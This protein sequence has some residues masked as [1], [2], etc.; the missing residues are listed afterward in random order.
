MSDK[1]KMLR[2]LAAVLSEQGIRASMVRQTTEHGMPHYA[3]SIAYNNRVY[4]LKVR[5]RDCSTTITRRLVPWKKCD[6]PGPLL[7][8]PQ[9]FDKLKGLLD[10]WHNE[11][12]TISTS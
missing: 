2:A 5:W 3:V 9:F 7:E 10:I 4:L 6:T 12:Q 11:S 8:D 1:E